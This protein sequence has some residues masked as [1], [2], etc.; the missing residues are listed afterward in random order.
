MIRGAV[1][2]IKEPYARV[3]FKSALRLE[4]IAQRI[5]NAICGGTGF[6][7]DNFDEFPAMRLADIFGLQIHIVEC[8][9]NKTYSLLVECHQQLRPPVTDDE[10]IEGIA[11]SFDANV[12]YEELF[13]NRADLSSY[14]GFLLKQIPGIE[15]QAQESA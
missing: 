15:I 5:S 8:A 11:K 14:F 2:T 4:D 9:A 13:P 1:M 3:S 10:L 7:P 6:E 12:T